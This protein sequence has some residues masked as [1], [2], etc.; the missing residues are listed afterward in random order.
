MGILSDNKR[1]TSFLAKEDCPGPGKAQGML[2]TIVS[3]EMVDLNPGGRT[4]EHKP[5]LKTKEHPAMVLNPTNRDW[6]LDRFGDDQLCVGKTVLI[7]HDPDVEFPR[8]KKVG[9]LRIAD[10][11]EFKGDIP[12]EFDD[13]IP[14]GDD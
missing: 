9:G 8:G 7:W 13:D 10:A 12:G 3:F 2:A 4:P 14:F 6:L 1:D 5:I 11:M